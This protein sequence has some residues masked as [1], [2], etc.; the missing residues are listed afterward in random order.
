MNKK[1]ISKLEKSQYISKHFYNNIEDKSIIPIGFNLDT[2]NNK[3][4]EKELEKYKDYFDNMYLNIDPNIHLDL[5]QRKAILSDEDFSLII[6]GAG[7]GKTTTMASKVKYLVDKKG[8]PP[9][10][11]LVMS[12]TKK[13]T[14][15]LEKRIC[16][17]FNIPA[18]VTTFHSL[19]YMH[20]REIFNN[21]K[22]YIVDTN[23]R[24]KIFY[25]YFKEQI[26][27]FKNKVAEFIKLYK[28]D[29]NTWIF[30]KH[31]LSNY[32]KYSSYEEYFNA[33]KN[34]KISEFKDDESLSLA[35][36]SKIDNSLNQENIL[37]LKD[38]L[39]KSKGE[40]VI[41]NFLFCNNINYQY[42]AIYD[43]LMDEN[44]VYRPDFTLELHGEKVYIEYF[45]FSGEDLL[46]KEKYQRQKE[47]KESYHLKH[48]NKFISI[49]YNTEGNIRN[50]L[51]QELIRLGFSLKPL[52]NI[53]IYD[54]ILSNNPLSQIYPLV[55]FFYNM[56]DCIKSNPKREDYANIIKE[57]INNLPQEEQKVAE[58]Q[59]YYILEFYKYY[60][61]NLYGNSDYG[62]DFSDLIFYA[63]KY[64]STIGTNNNLN[65]E[66]IIIDEYQDISQER[67][68]FT[69]S[70]AN[71]NH[72]KIVA[73]GDDWQSIYGFSGSKVDYTYNFQ[74]YFKDSK[75]LKISNTYRNCQSLIDYSGKFIM[76]NEDQI[77][78]DLYS[79]KNI[80]NP[81]RF[82]IF[83]ETIEDEYKTLKKLILKIHKDNPTHKIMIL[84][85]NNSMINKCF[86]EI[87]LKDDI[88]TKIT[89]IGYEDICIDG[90]TIHKSKG[91]TCDEV[92]I[93]GLN[94]NFPSTDHS[95][96]WL[97]SIFKPPAIEEQIPYAEER[98]IFYVALTRT[99]NYVYLLANK[100]AKH[101]SPF[102]DEIAYIM[103]EVNATEEEEII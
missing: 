89:F 74:K 44:K 82:V 66:Y 19:G 100:N 96:F 43:N 92:I 76:R 17:D 3:V 20:I 46:S 87:D 65:F 22:C 75:L 14:L 55:E 58:R 71:R 72:A 13:S 101:R 103:N 60:Q 64:I 25:N 4:L 52:S 34:F 56:I 18:K 61:K 98:R 41:A 48:H 37:T 7:T 28:N 1:F 81:I 77:K 9:E 45:G 93:I 26:F 94:N 70:I 102:V 42:E 39:V 5:E 83:D 79:S 91:L 97:E 35:I 8:I 6:A 33:Y 67:Y 31:F 95:C 12:Y 54:A 59:I 84:A 50:Y 16:Y 40:A 38:E 30:S 68:E 49:S 86:N 51:Y 27:P 57:Y 73:V 24:R 32:E 15:E 47:L 78:K 29:K 90:M 10:K 62:F 80:S 36:K 2:Y 69:K 99:K 63:N 21:R 85:R 23:I 11:I 53:E 88:G